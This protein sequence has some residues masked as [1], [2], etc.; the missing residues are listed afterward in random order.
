[1]N[2]TAILSA[3]SLALWGEAAGQREIGLACAGVRLLV[4]FQPG[5][6]NLSA[7]SLQRAALLTSVALAL[8]ILGTL[9]FFGLPNG[10]LIAFGWMPLP[11][12]PLVLIAA[13]NQEP[14]RWRHLSRLLPTT[15]PAADRVAEL[16]APYFAATLLAAALLV[17]TSTWFFWALAGLLLVW[18]FRPEKPRNA[19]QIFHFALAGGLAVG[20]GIFGS[21][22]LRSSQQ[23]L[24]DWFIDVLSGVDHD[25]YQ[26]QTSIGDLGRLKL[27]DRVIWRLEQSAPVQVPLL[28]RSGVFSRYSQGAWYANPTPFTPLQPLPAAADYKPWLRL[29]GES[30]QGLAMIPLP[31]LAG[32]VSAEAGQLNRNAQGI[33]QITAA[34]SRVNLTVSADSMAR[35]LPPETSDLALPPDWAGRLQKMPEIA[36]FRA[37]SETEKLSRLNQWFNEHFRY[38]LSLGD[39]QQGG[40]TLEKFLTTDRAG[41]CEFFATATVLIL[42][43]L[44]IP[45]RYVTGFSVQE[46]SRLEKAFVLRQR[47][48]HAWAEAFVEGRWVEIDNTPAVWAESEAAQSS[49]WQPLTDFWSYSLRKLEEWGHRRGTAIDQGLISVLVLSIAALLVAWLLRK[50]WRFRARRRNGQPPTISPQLNAPELN[51]LRALERELAA[52]GLPRNPAEPPRSWLSRVEREGRSVLDPA[53]L[54]EARKIINLLYQARYGAP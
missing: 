4:A 29:Q 46:Y 32:R 36:T 10:L 50:Y 45:A 30:R 14:V 40:R 1:M 28:L 31:Q 33:V 3:F 13:I 48:A 34:P 17:K 37:L 41:H 2:W 15:N 9:S 54:S 24:Q 5:R 49:L 12:L 7:H 21:T 43:A 38:T 11:L 23:T 27:S 18:L 16:E 35:A 25:P 44:D 8:E 51:L 6:L 42:R 26:R 22:L 53:R 52:L 47:H 19:R 39:E 20:I